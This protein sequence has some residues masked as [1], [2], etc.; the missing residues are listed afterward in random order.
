MQN[1]KNPTR[2][3]GPLVANLTIQYCPGKPSNKGGIQLEYLS[4]HENH[5]DKESADLIRNDDIKNRLNWF[6][7]SLSDF[8]NQLFEE[9]TPAT[10]IYIPKNIACGF[11]GGD[12]PM[13]TNIIKEFTK[14][15]YAAGFT[16]ILVKKA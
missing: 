10:N 15:L 8:R 2:N 16:T 9:G 14:E 13:Y 5:I 7:E 1:K 6:R 4:E 11:S 3:T 12:G